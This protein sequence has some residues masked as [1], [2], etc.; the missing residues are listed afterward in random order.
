MSNVQDWS[1][2]AASNNSAAPNGF[3]EG[4]APS[5]VND[6]S[7]EVMAAVARFFGD[8]NG[9]I[10]AGGTANA[11]TITSNSSLSALSDGDVF[12]FEAANDNSG[13]TTLAVDGLS[14]VSIVYPGG[15]ALSGGEIVTGGRYIVSY[16]GTNFQLIGAQQVGS[17]VQAHSDSLDEIAAL[18]TTD[19]NFIVGNGSAWV[20]E[21]G[22]TARSSLGLGSLA[23]ASS[24]NNSNW[25]GTDLAVTNGGTG[26][27][28]AATARSNLG[29]MIDP[30]VSTSSPSGGSN[31]DFWFVREA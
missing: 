20:A 1:T 14:A 11:I 25:S 15:T 28:T 6:A 2:S 29:A 31:G 30:T 7:R 10:T 21:S 18:A 16:D 23:T 26:A 5:T 13:A 19:G 8:W 24:I 3:P 17:Q 4:M 9:S 12:M 22:A 27:S